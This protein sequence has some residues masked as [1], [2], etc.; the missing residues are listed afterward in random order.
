MALAGAGN[1]NIAV[2]RAYIGDI[3][4]DE[5]LKAR[6]GVIGAAFGLG[7]MIGPFI[8]GILTDPY[9]NFGGVF[10][11]SWWQSHPY[12]LPCLFAG[13]LSL[14][15]FVLAIK[16]LPESLPLEARSKEKQET[17][18]VKQLL[19]NLIR[20]RDLSRPVQILI[21]VNAIFL[22]SFT[23]MHTTFILF[24]GMPTESGGLGYDAKANGYIFAFVG[25]V[26]VLVH[27]GFM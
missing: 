19:G 2:A 1:G 23:I 11:T 25:L 24:T 4:T 7:F 10:E 6:M 3:S 27:G 9:T 22:T 26:G 16:Q 5:Q 21:L 17:N 14:V 15:S 12:F 8:G 13:L 20:V 18:Y